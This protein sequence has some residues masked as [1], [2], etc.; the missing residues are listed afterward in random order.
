VAIL[1]VRSSRVSSADAERWWTNLREA[2]EAGIFFYAVTALNVA[3][4]KT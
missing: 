2:H 4:T 3:G 1:P